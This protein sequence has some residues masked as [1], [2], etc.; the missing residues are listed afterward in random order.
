[1]EDDD[2]V[3]NGDDGA[4]DNDENGDDDSC[5]IKICKVSR[6]WQEVEQQ[7]AKGKGHVCLVKIY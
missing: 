6:S 1:M 3:D 7:F 2:D 5:A 4:D